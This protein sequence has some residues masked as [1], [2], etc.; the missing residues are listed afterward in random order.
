MTGG[1]TTPG[2]GNLATVYVY[3]PVSNEWLAPLSNFTTPRDFHAAFIVT[4]PSTSSKMLCVAGGL[5]AAST[6]FS[7]TQCYD[8]GAGSWNAESADIG[9][10]P[11]GWWGMGYAQKRHAGNEQ[12]L[13][14]TAGS[15]AGFSVIGQTYNF[16]FDTGVWSDGGALPSGAVYR[17]SAVVLNNDIYKL[18]G[19]SGGFTSVGWIDHHLQC[20][21]CE[22]L[23]FTDIPSGFWAEDSIYAIA[24]EGIT[25]GYA[26]GTYRPSQN[27]QRSQMAAFIIRPEYGED[28]SYSPTPHFTD[29]LDTHWAFKYVQ[30]MYDEGIT[31][32]YPDGTYRPSQ[33]VTRGQMAAFIIKALFGD[34][35]S[36]TL[37]PYFTDVPDSHGF[38]N[39]IQKMYDEG[40]TT[41]Y[42]DGTYRP[43]QNVSRAQMA[44][45]IAKAFLGM[46]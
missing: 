44:T 39:Y 35:F 37:T 41:G 12:Q 7:S 2:G 22:S 18:G 23:S 19:A 10:L 13:W 30:K 40:I 28:F 17:N 34:S 25:S 3:N 15:D 26:D 32:G 6:V 46:E 5:D 27:V 21:G 24:C 42:P 16:S 1:A 11:F 31:T 36:Y 8:F 38:F 33:N 4:K 9:T 14:L 45:F 20:K 29:V 43:S